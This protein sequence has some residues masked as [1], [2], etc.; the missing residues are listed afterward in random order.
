LDFIL[1][2]LHSMEGLSRRTL[3]LDA[4]RIINTAHCSPCLPQMPSTMQTIWSTHCQNRASMY[5]NNVLCGLWV[6]I[7]LR[8]KDEAYIGRR[9]VY[10]HITYVWLI[11][12]ISNIICVS[13]CMVSSYTLIH[14]VQVLLSV[15]YPM[16]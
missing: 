7:D 8:G 3:L 12:N 4:T 14:Q 9:V 5:P 2:A 10:G 15:F 11:F 13:V 16:T 6:S 1:P